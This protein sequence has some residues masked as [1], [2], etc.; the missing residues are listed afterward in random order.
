MLNICVY[1]EIWTILSITKIQFL[2]LGEFELVNFLSLYG[3]TITRF[4]ILFLLLGLALTKLR[5]LKFFLA[6]R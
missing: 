3:R 6:S 5:F 4:L 2:R 1:L